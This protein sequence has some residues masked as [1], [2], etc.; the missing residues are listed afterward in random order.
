M[1]KKMQ[2]IRKITKT[3]KRVNLRRVFSWTN[4]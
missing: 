4:I 2:E 1:K 3:I